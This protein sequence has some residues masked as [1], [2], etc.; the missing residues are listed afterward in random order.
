MLLK[1]YGD[2]LMRFMNSDYVAFDNENSIIVGIDGKSIYENAISGKTCYV[3]KTP[4]FQYAKTIADGTK[5]NGNSSYT[6]GVIFGTGNDAVTPND[7]KLSGD[8][9]TLA[10]SQ[11]IAT[12]VSNVFTDEYREMTIDFTI[13]NNTSADITI[14]EVAICSRYTW[15][16][17]PT[18][19]TYFPYLIERTPLEK[20][21]TI[22]SGANG[23][24]TYV[25]RVYYP[26]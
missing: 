19:G 14:G 4:I 13:S 21:L 5:F 6:Q 2:T 23:K 24:I 22:A 17:A 3:E 18:M 16:N 12:E 26:I 20:P 1:N 25:V 7:Y 8:V 10:T 15:G 9:I 11:I